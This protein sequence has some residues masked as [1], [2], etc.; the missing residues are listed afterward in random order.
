LLVGA[1]TAVLVTSAAA[2]AGDVA[3]CSIVDRPTGFDH[4]NIT[5]HRSRWGL[6]V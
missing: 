5:W 3:I 4:Q 1:T 2:N 6:A